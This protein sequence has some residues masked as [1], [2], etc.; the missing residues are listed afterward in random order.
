MIYKYT[1]VMSNN[2]RLIHKIK[3]CIRYVFK[4]PSPENREENVV[5]H[6]NVITIITEHNC[7]F[8]Y[9]FFK[10]TAML[11]ASTVLQKHLQ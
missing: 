4:T 11:Y 7:H 10:V 8:Y 6:S 1:A 3:A 5:L 9:S 2:I